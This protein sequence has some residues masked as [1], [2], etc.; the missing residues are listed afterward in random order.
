VGF[1]GLFLKNVPPVCQG[2]K[3]GV[4]LAEIFYQ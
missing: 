1:C 4:I 2:E 3:E